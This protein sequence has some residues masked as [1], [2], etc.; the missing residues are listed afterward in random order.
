MTFIVPMGGLKDMSLW[1][2]WFVWL[3][4]PLEGCKRC[5]NFPSRTNWSRWFHRFLQSS[6]VCPWSWWYWQYRLWLCFEE[7]LAILF[8]H[9]KNGS[10]LT[11]SKTCRTDSLNT[12]LTAYV[13]VDPDCPVKSLLG[14]LLLYRSDLKSFLLWRMIFS[15]CF[16]CSW[17]FSTLLYLSIWSI[18]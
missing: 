17:S 14:W 7:S 11:F 9:L 16:P 2:S 8:G 10:F 18:N 13:L 4:W 15:F 12:A 5:R 1:G 6:V 3:G